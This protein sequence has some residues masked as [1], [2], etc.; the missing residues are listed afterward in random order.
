[1]GQSHQEPLEH[2]EP[3]EQLNQDPLGHA[4]SLTGATRMPWLLYK[5]SPSGQQEEGNS[6]LTS[7]TENTM[8][9]NLSQTVNL[10]FF[11]LDN[12]QQHRTYKRKCMSLGQ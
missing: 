6:R 5:T 9:T 12:S 4:G 10:Y 3:L 8:T 2:Y 11:G 7:S 1:M